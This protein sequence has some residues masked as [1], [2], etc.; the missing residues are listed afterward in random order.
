MYMQHGVSINIFIFAWVA[1]DCGSTQNQEGTE[2][3]DASEFEVTPTSLE[4][5]DT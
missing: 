3:E 5:T 4:E 2:A 1:K